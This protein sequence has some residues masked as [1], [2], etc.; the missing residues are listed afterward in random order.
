MTDP[1]GEL[2]AS[3]LG[4]TLLRSKDI[5][6]R[7]RCAIALA[8]LP[9][10]SKGQIR[11]LVQGLR[12]NKSG[13][14]RFWCSL[15]LGRFVPS[16]AQK[17]LLALVTVPHALSDASVRAQAANSLRKIALSGKL[18]GAERVA[19]SLARRLDPKK[20]T[21][22]RVRGEVAKTLAVLRSSSKSVLEALHKATTDDKFDEVRLWA[23]G[24]LAIRGIGPKLIS[25]LA[26]MVDS[27]SERSI[28]RRR[29]AL[30][31]GHTG[32]ELAV[33]ALTRSLCREDPQLRFVAATALGRLGHSAS[34]AASQIERALEKEQ[35][36]LVENRAR[37]SLKLIKRAHAREIG[38]DIKKARLAKKK[39]R[40]LRAWAREMG[41]TVD[42]ARAW[43]NGTEIP[44]ADPFWDKIRL[45]LGKH[46]IRRLV[47]EV[48]ETSRGKIT[49]G[50]KRPSPH[51]APKDQRAAPD[52]A[53]R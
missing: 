26:K 52:A 21:N 33:P 15:A 41:V 6:E 9:S 4:P 2:N 42:V 5:P 31:L 45:L 37:S 19:R 53:K 46:S 32:N 39:F 10:A 24:G 27:D 8:K 51:P 35:H 38:R 36:S 47:P 43:E 23:A 34:G 17:G 12:D 44:A 29:A 13:D 18:K 49:P 11:A 3:D 25:A 40:D 20:E 50:R 22:P 16:E 7:L 14:V 30:S 48:I 28:T 1:P